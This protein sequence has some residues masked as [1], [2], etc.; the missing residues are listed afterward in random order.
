ME[1]FIAWSLSMRTCD[2]PRPS[3][4]DEA[5]WSPSSPSGNRRP[6]EAAQPVARSRGLHRDITPMNVFVCKNMKLKL[7]DF[8]LARHALAGKMV[9]ASA[10]TPFFVSKRMAEGEGVL[11]ALR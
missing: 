1:C 8:G 3:G 6:A 9:M 2:D 5:G 11:A 7:G 10:F 4:F